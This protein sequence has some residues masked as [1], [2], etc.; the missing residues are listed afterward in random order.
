MNSCDVTEEQQDAAGDDY[1]F[2]GSDEYSVAQYSIDMVANECFKSHHPATDKL[3]STVSVE[4]QSAV[5]QLDTGASSCI[6]SQE[7]FDKLSKKFR[8]KLH[9]KQE[10]MSVHLADGSVSKKPCKNVWLSVKSHQLARPQRLNFIIMSGSK[11]LLGRWAMYKLWPQQY[12][13]FKDAISASQQSGSV[14]VSE[15]I[16]DDRQLATPVVAVAAGSMTS[17][18]SD[19]TYQRPGWSK[20]A[21]PAHHGDVAG[22]V[23]EEDAIVAVMKEM[24]KQ[25]CSLKQVVLELHGHVHGGEGVQQARGTTEDSQYGEGCE[26]G[27]N[28]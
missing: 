20:S 23:K 2:L 24:C 7:L 16:S 13:T 15:R 12:S 6:M 3:M 26:F 5:F 27:D 10:K 25:L 21:S 14:V 11:N 22:S 17:S 18:Q 19:S 4:G 1:E 8:R 9:V 28:L